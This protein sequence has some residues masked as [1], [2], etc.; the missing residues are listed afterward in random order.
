[1][2]IFRTRQQRRFLSVAPKRA[3]YNGGWVGGSEKDI[4]GHSKRSK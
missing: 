4:V 2:Q 1:M 3:G